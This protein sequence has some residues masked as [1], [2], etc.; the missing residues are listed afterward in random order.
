MGFLVEKAFDKGGQFL[1]DHGIEYHAL[2][3]VKR[4]NEDN[5]MELG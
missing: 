1:R 2:A 4:I 5:T 3:T